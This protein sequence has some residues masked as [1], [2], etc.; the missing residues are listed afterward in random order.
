VQLK[1]S[2]DKIKIVQIVCEPEKL[3]QKK[4]LQRVEIS[5]RNAR[6]ELK[7]DNYEINHI[8]SRSRTHIYSKLF[9]RKHKNLLEQT[10][11]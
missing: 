3:N 11:Y 9:R 8:L 5:Y 2:I 6:Q 7:R 1:S 4:R 10:I